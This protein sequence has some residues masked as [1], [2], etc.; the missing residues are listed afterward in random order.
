MNPFLTPPPLDG[1]DRLFESH[2]RGSEDYFRR[3]DEIVQ[4]RQNCVLY[5]VRGAGKTSLLNSYF[6]PERLCFLAQQEG[7]DARRTIV[8]R[9]SFRADENPDGLSISI[10]LLHDLTAA[11]EELLDQEALGQEARTALE[12]AREQARCT[13]TPEEAASQTAVK[14]ALDRYILALRAKG[15]SVVVVWDHFD[16][17]TFSQKI[18]LDDHNFMCALLKASSHGEKASFTFLAV[19]DNDLHRGSLPYL[20][21]IDGSKFLE[22]LKEHRTLGPISHKDVKAFLVGHLEKVNEGVWFSQELR[23]EIC[24][25]SGAIPGLLYIAAR[26]AYDLVYELSGD[27]AQY[28]CLAKKEYEQGKSSLT[29]GEAAQLTALENQ[30]KSRLQEKLVEAYRITM[31]KSWFRSFTEI[32]KLILDEMYAPKDG[33]ATGKCETKGMFSEETESLIDR[34]ILIQSQEDPSGTYMAVSSL[35]SRVYLPW[36]EKQQKAQRE[37]ARE[38]VAERPASPITNVTYYN[39]YNINVEHVSVTANILGMLGQQGQML[40]AQLHESLLGAIFPNG[41]P[42][43]IPLEGETQEAFEQRQ[44]TAFAEATKELAPSTDAAEL[45]NLEGM[46]RE[47]LTNPCFAS[48]DQK[49]LDGLTPACQFYVKMAV[50]I[51]SRLSFMELLPSEQMDYSAQLVFYGKALEQ[52]LKD[53]FFTR[54]QAEPLG[55]FTTNV[56]RGSRRLTFAEL[57]KSDTTIGTYWNL[58]RYSRR[59]LAELCGEAG[60]ALDEAWWRELYINLDQAGHIRNLADHSGTGKKWNPNHKDGGPLPSALFQLDKRISDLEHPSKDAMGLMFALLFGG[61][62]DAGED[63]RHQLTGVFQRIMQVEPLELP[64]LSAL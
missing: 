34:G 9:H 33:K 10:A 42:A 26:H 59:Q 53:R 20:K 8:C 7:V 41:R 1:P 17:F 4:G 47:A 18:S 63:A 61:E 58:I 38:Q 23:A 2:R 55:R 11:V 15:F 22:E 60:M 28:S 16:E 24:R 14:A 36:R 49:V 44:E 40:G 52:F 31:E 39:T 25:C 30:L 19:T 62:V 12:K 35:M 51:Q 3:L 13:L 29:E 57:K 45:E 48:L 46:F 21:S 27:E 37:Q 32:E 64:S 6:T 5:G 50:V 43:L 54:F 56:T